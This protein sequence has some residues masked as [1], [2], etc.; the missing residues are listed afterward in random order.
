MRGEVLFYELVTRLYK[1]EGDAAKG[2]GRD[3][4]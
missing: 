2:G 1:I 3:A 4:P